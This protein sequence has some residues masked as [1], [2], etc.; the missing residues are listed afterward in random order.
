MEGYRRLKEQDEFTDD[1]DPIVTR[2]KMDAWGDSVQQFLAK[3]TLTRVA[4]KRNDEIDQEELEFRVK[5]STLYKLYQKFAEE[6]ELE[7]ESKKAFTQKVKSKKG[8][9]QGRYQFQGEGSLEQKNGFKGI[10]LEENAYKEIKGG[11]E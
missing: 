1:R 6:N 11:K 10:K 2:Q 8:V 3:Y 7:I 5:H 9:M 4:A